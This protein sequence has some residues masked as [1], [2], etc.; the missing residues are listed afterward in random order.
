[1]RH[2]VLVGVALLFTALSAPLVA[3]V[4][5]PELRARVT[6][7]TATLSDAQRAALEEKL[8]AFERRKGAQ[9]AVLLVAS[10]Q[11]EPIEDYAIRVAERW[12]LGRSGVDDGALLVVA[13]RDRALRIEVGYGLEGA[14][15]DATARRIVD[16][17]IVPRFRAGDFHGGIDAGVDRILAVIDGEPLPE[18][19]WDRDAGGGFEGLAAVLP[20]VFVFTATLGAVLKRLI[21]QLPG[22]LLTGAAT[23]FLAWALVGVATVALLAAVAAFVLT[24][25][26][27]AG[28]GRWASGRGGGGFGGG[29]GSAGGGGGGFSG[30]GGGFGGCGASGRW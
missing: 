2:L 25:L 14:L 26:S 15:T 16:E 13:T 12:R 4:A 21:G 10:T 17:F 23:G 20:V 1:M 24:L 30:G 27:R 6:D 29:F 19:A 5:V 18:P 11:P 9:V 8:A 28:P 22:A 3:D 7:L